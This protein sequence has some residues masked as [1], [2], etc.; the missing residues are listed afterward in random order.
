MTTQKRTPE[1]II[2]LTSYPARIRY[3]SQTLNR[4][5]NQTVKPDR[6][7]LWLSK[8]Q[9]P[10]G[11]RNLPFRLHEMK[12]RGLQIEWCEKDIKAYKKLIPALE[13]YPEAI[14]ITVDDD[15][16]YD[17]DLIE[18]LIDCH[19]MYPTAIIASRVHKIKFLDNG[20]IAAYS[21]WEKEISTDA[22]VPR[23]DLFVTGGAGTLFPPHIFNDEVFNSEV[24][25]KE[26][27]YAD[28]IWIN[29]MA[30]LSKCTIVHTG[31]NRTLTYVPGTQEDRLFAININKN[32]E[33]LGKLV[34][35][36]GENIFKLDN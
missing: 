4:L 14:I 27:P 6:I 33:Q 24:F 5:M 31:K 22:W 16:V 30:R 11:E 21:E 23:Q 25:Q 36:Y 1:I 19:V 9:F 13:R 15:L 35:R 18:N 26:C 29:V 32:D 20:A 3:V 34:T 28:D 17:V 8:E 7:I 12:K 2:S 10:E